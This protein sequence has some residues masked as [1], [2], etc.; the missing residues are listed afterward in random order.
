[1]AALDATSNLSNAVAE[2]TA[3]ASPARGKNAPPPDLELRVM[4]S[5]DNHKLSFMLHGGATYNYKPV[6][7]TDLETTDPRALFADDAQSAERPGGPRRSHAHSRRNR[8]DQARACH[9][10]Q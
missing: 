6:G 4:L 3:V 9:S 7:E 5:G 10:G 2:P 1:M 8:G